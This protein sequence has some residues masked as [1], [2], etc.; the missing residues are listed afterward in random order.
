MQITIPQCSQR[1]QR[2]PSVRLGPPRAS[3]GGLLAWLVQDPFGAPK[4]R[5]NFIA[6]RELVAS[7]Q[8]A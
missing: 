3:D 6:E 2:S 1:S 5:T 4:P 7:L 8:D